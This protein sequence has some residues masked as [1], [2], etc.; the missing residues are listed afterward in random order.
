[1]QQGLLIGVDGGGTHSVAVAVYPN[2]KVA[3]AAHGGG[4]NYHNVGI[5]LVRRRLES[6]VSRLCRQCGEERVLKVCVGMSALDQPADRGTLSHFTGGSLTADQLD[7][8]SDAYIALMGLTQGRPGIIVISGTGSMVLLMDAQGRQ[9]ASGGWG[10]LLGDAGSGYTLAREGLLSVIDEAEGLGGSTRLTEHA[11]AYF[12][13]DNPRGLIDRIYDRRTAPDQ[14]AGFARWVLEEAGGG[15]EAAVA[16]VSRNMERLARQTA[17]LARQEPLAY[18]VG[19]YGGVFRHSALARGLFEQ[20]LIRLMPRAQVCLPAYP[21]E[22]GAII[23]LL[24]GEGSLAEDVLS[25]MKSTYE[26]LCHDC[27]ESIL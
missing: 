5:S 7:L 3:A 19:L 17:A 23:H 24:Q 6:L 9:H 15:D 12:H 18:R 14:F 20:N 21:P 4:L 11:L 27:R 25:R 2:G 16:V 13:T 26:V 8:Q 22:L 1:M 10:Y